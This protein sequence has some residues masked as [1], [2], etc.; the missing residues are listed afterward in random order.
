MTIQGIDIRGSLLAPKAHINFVAG[1]INGQLICKSLE[2]MGQMNLAPFIGN[3]PYE[4][5][6]TNTASV[7][8]VITNDPNPNNN[9]ASVKVTFSNTGSGNNGGGTGGNNWQ[10][11]N[12]FANGEIVYT[13]LYKSGKIYAGTWG[14]KIYMS[15]NNG[16]TWSII[17]NGMNVYYIWSLQASGSF[18]F[19]AT[20]QGVFKFNGTTWA[21]TSLSGKDVHALATTSTAGT[22]YAGTWGFGV[23]KSTDY[24]TTWTAMNNGLS[25]FLTIQSLTVKGSAVF[26]GT[27]G[28]G[29]FKSINGG[30]N[31]TQIAVGNN[32]IWALGGTASAVFAS[33]FG[34]GLYR[35][36]DNGATWAKLTLNVP[37]VYAIVNYSSTTV[38]VAS[39][40]SGVF[41][42]TDNGNTWTSL[43]MG[44]L[45]VSS[46]VVNEDNE[47]VMIGTKEGKIYFSNN[48]GLTDVDDNAMPST[49]ELNQNYPNPF[50]PSTTIQFALPEA[51]RFTLKIYNIVGQE[52][53]TLVEGELN[54]GIHK[55]NF[56]AS[57]LA[58]G[59]YIYKLVGNNVNISKKM[60]LMK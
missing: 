58:S 4:K 42:S 43:G 41:K 9:S 27:V 14:G 50:N 15:S 47:N 10:Q 19:A 21:L 38:Y 51:G 7:H 33:S 16:Q 36:L 11:V 46:V 45:G 49:V 2:G 28:G 39:Y 18:I 29:V 35:S 8:S 37:Y 48:S 44:G 5:E 32:M 54:S 59:V 20:E 23:Y 40:A 34:D 3:I 57:R 13:L 30:T 56:D 1:V 52:V 60:I 25:Y 17:N 26:A 55:V 53:A 12:G 6:V 31:W 24:G 22:I